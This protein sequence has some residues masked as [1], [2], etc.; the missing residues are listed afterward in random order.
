MLSVCELLPV[1]NVVE[2]GRQLGVKADIRENFT[3][4]EAK[5]V[6]FGMV[7]QLL[8]ALDDKIVDT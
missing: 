1:L 3:R 7:L 4:A 8:L 6:G 2:L 5:V